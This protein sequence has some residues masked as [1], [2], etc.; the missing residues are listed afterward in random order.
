M[1]WLTKIFSGAS[2]GIVSSIGEVADKFIET[3]EDK[4]KFKLEMESLLQKRD[5]EME[6]TARSELEAKQNI[7]VAELQQGDTYTK[8][9]RPTIV[10][11]GLAVT[12]F[13]Y[14]LIPLIQMFMGHEINA[15]KP[16]ELPM[17]FWVA[18]AGVTGTWTVGR[19]L[20]R[21]G[22]RNR[23]TSFITGNSISQPAQSTQLAKG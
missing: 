6:Q 14:C 8:R 16:F 13:N 5:S 4:K 9:A 12:V 1:D 21:N 3:S 2:G 11:V 7:L 15:I 19:T 18:W 10:Y 22:Y 17:E 23:V 20:E